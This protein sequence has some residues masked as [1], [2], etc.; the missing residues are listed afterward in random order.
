M[1][2]QYVPASGWVGH[3]EVEEVVEETV[4]EVVDVVVVAAGMEDV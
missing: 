4:S 1:N 2:P 3:V